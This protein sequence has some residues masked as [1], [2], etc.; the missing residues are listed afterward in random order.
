MISVSASNDLIILWFPFVDST[1]SGNNAR[2]RRGGD[3]SGLTACCFRSHEAH[4]THLTRNGYA[5][6]KLP[7]NI[8]WRGT[9]AF[10]R[11]R[12]RLTATRFAGGSPSAGAPAVRRRAPPRGT[13]AAECPPLPAGRAD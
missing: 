6:F 11:A 1:A 8:F 4:D 13:A 7:A 5:K 10:N 3:L 9:H 12:K 2:G